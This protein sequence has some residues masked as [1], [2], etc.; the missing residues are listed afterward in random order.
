MTYENEVSYLESKIKNIQDN[1]NLLNTLKC[2]KDIKTLEDVKNFLSNH[3]EY[4]F[5]KIDL[6]MDIETIKGKLS[7]ILVEYMIYKEKP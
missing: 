5:N 4:N 1:Q 3:N 2:L 7:Y 6:D